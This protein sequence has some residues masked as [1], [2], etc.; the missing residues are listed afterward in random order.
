MEP[1]LTEDCSYM[2]LVLSYRFSNFDFN[3]SVY[4]NVYM[5]INLFETITFLKITTCIS[6]LF[7]IAKGL[8][9]FRLGGVISAQ[10]V[11]F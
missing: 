1:I 11:Q 3:F 5:Y 8:A 9:T 4:G 6:F 2:N 7:C 10:K